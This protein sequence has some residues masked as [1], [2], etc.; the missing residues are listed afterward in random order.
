MADTNATSAV[1]NQVLVL[2]LA[3]HLLSRAWSN[4]YDSGAVWKEPARLA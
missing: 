1:Q 3:C 4:R 2:I